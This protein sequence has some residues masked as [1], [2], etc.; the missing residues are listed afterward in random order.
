MFKKHI[1]VCNNKRDPSTHRKCCGDSGNQIR[2]EIAKRIHEECVTTTVRANK[3]GCLDGCELGPVVVIYPQNIWYGGV[4]P[5][6]T[7][8]IFERSILKNEI[9]ERLLISPNAWDSR[10]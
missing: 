5:A 2:S 3:C 1:F 9:I 6:D 4:T 10:K 8:E 7:D